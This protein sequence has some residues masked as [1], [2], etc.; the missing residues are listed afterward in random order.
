MV[1]TEYQ[2]RSS[3]CIYTISK[4]KEGNKKLPSGA[5]LQMRA[6]CNSTG[7]SHRFCS[8]CTQSTKWIARE[9]DSSAI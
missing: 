5:N 8:Y 4:M 1:K 9:Q 3:S 2:K 7:Q 6:N